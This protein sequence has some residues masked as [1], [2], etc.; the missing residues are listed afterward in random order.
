MERWCSTYQ[1][2]D[3]RLQTLQKLIEK[4]VRGVSRHLGSIAEEEIDLETFMVPSP[5]VDFKGGVGV[6]IFYN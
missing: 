2:T 3:R 1:K 6:T 5:E 4:N